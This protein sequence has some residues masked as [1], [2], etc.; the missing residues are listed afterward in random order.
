VEAVSISL[1]SVSFARLAR[2]RT[3][4]NIKDI[5][6]S[7]ELPL[8]CP[9]GSDELIIQFRSLWNVIICVVFVWDRPLIGI[10]AQRAR[11]CWLG[12]VYA[13]NKEGIRE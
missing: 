9:H 1:C 13:C 8:K 3:I 12:N 6:T 7:T 10:E 2:F 4:A 5:L 11:R